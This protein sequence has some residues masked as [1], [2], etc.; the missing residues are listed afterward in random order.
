MEGFG[1]II[2]GAQ[3]QPQNAVDLVVARRAVEDEDVLTTAQNGCLVTIAY[4]K[5]ST[6]R[7][8]FGPPFTIEKCY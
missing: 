6:F 7:R 8:L 1:D 4:R 2:I 3:F 5:L